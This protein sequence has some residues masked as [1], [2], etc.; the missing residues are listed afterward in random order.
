[1]AQLLIFR[2]KKNG[3]S[4]DLFSI[5]HVFIYIY[6]FLSFEPFFPN[7]QFTFCG[8]YLN[9]YSLLFVD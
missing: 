9:A 2:R 5:A 7:A 8:W 6:I 4:V 3:F 1:M